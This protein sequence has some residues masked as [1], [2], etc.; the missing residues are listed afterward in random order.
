VATVA[1][2]TRDRIL[3][4][5]GD[6]FGTRGVDAVSLDE[7][8]GAVGVRKQTVLYWFASKE[9]LVDAVLEATADEIAVVIDAALRAAPDEP[10]E[11]VD[12]VVRAVFRLAVR[13]PAVLGLV[14]ELSRLPAAQA[15]RL[16]PHVD[17][18]VARAVDFLGREMDAGRLRPGDPRLVAA[19]AYGTVTGIATEPEA[20]RG[21]GWTPSPAGLRRLRAELRS[22]LRAALAP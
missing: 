12:T 21:V 18:L 13:R 5:A 20:L 11:R 4:V 6:R 7:I 8:A 15:D 16:R 2:S 10:L 19:L 1:T 9:E 22:F 17:P 14:R 3:A